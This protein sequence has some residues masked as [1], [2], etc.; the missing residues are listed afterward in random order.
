MV[1]YTDIHIY[2]SQTGLIAKATGCK[3]TSALARLPEHNYLTQTMPNVMHTVK[4]TTERLYHLIV[5]GTVQDFL[6]GHHYML[7]YA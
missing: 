3:I 1:V 6:H 5:S 4:D 2:R 7:L